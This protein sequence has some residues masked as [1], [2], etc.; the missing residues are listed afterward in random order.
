MKEQ[1]EIKLWHLRQP[2]PT[3]RLSNFHKKQHLKIP[4]GKVFSIGCMLKTSKSYKIRYFEVDLK[5]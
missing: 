1:V 4:F 2:V 5:N 3:L